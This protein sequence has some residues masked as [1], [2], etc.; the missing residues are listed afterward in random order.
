M[1]SSRNF[2]SVPPPSNLNSRQSYSKFEDVDAK[3][4]AAR[5][6]FEMSLKSKRAKSFVDDDDYFEHDDDNDVCHQKNT[7]ADEDEDD[8]VD[9]LDAFMADLNKS[10]NVSKSKK[11]SEPALMKMSSKKDSLK[12]VR[13]DIEEED[14]EES[15]Y[16]YMES[17]PNA[18]VGTLLL[19]SDDEN[20][21]Q[22]TVEYDDDGNPIA[23]TGKKMIDPLPMV[24]HSQIEYKPFEKNFYSEHNDIKQLTSSEVNELRRKQGIRVSG[25]QPPKPCTSFAHF[26]FDESLMKVIRKLEYTQPTPIQA[27]ALPAALSGR[28]IIGIAKTGSGKTAAFIW[29][30]LVHILDQPELKMGDGPIGLILAPTRELSQQIYTEAKRFSKPFGIHVVCAYGGGSKYEQSKDLEQGTDILVGT[31]VW[32]YQFKFFLFNF[33]F[34]LSRE[35]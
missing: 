2:R 13:Q 16:K 4:S 23:P 27:Q 20:A 3:A 24:Y 19:D 12:G 26:G 30:L 29:P 9:P 34:G 17:N 8:E 5:L 21:G 35:E 32:L 22:Q 11:V 18:G 6:K 10:E 25:L 14:E 15:Y 33:L 31:P 1:S 7:D 28:D